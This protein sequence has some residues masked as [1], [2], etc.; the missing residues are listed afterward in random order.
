MRPSRLSHLR[1][2]RPHVRPPSRIVASTPNIEVKAEE[3][4][5]C[6][7]KLAVQV[8]AERIVEEFD[9]TYKAAGKDLAVP[10]FRK[11]KIPV[12][13]LRGI[14]GGQ[15]EADAKNHL[16][17]H[18]VRD[19]VAQAEL[20]ALRVVNFDMDQYEVDEEKPLDFEV[21]VE[22]TPKVELPEWSELDIKPEPVIIN[23]EHIDLTLEDIRQKNLRFD[24]TE[25]DQALDEEHAVEMDLQYFLDGEGGPDA[26]DIR[27]GLES[28]LYGVEEEEWATKMTGAKKGDEV[29]LACEFNEGFAVEDWVGKTGEVKI[30]VK[31]LVKPRPATDEEI[32]EQGEF[33]AEELRDKIKEGLT[34]EAERAERNRQAD[35]MLQAIMDRRPFVLAQG[36]I[37]EETKQTIE[38]EVARLSEQGIEEET[39]REQVEGQTEA[40]AEAA[41]KRLK[42]YFLIRRIAEQE[43]IPVTKN[44][45]EQALRAISQHHGVDVKTVR[46]VYAQQGRL[47][48]VASDILT[49]K[50]RAF[51]I[52]QVEENA[53][54]V[55]A[56]DA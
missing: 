26:K 33:P 18:V 4:G 20:V 35:A 43:E 32:A 39:A 12:H 48:D 34:Q 13:V 2:A 27:L 14:L 5:P 17:E 45:M 38:Q 42:S 49:G 41:E 55:E 47:D 40:I 22:T 31:K 1:Q 56:E 15:V 44:E 16:F 30:E 46:N 29:T 54:A 21:E 7:Y 51:L 23:D 9:H 53:E 50:V 52:K 3:I 24:E 25:E 10:G 36:M 11:G 28:P 6:H 8:P 19:A 37:D